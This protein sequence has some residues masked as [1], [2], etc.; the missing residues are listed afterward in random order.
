M[1]KYLFPQLK[2]KPLRKQ[3]DMYCNWK[4]LRYPLVANTQRRVIESFFQFSGID[5]TSLI[6]Q[7]M[8]ESY[9]IT[10]HSIFLQNQTRASL[11]QFCKYWYKLG[12]LTDEFGRVIK[13]D[14]ITDMENVHPLMHTD[15][16]ERVHRLRKEGLSLRQIK[17]KMEMQDGKSYH[18]RQIHRWANYK[19]SELST[20][21]S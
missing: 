10:N 13:K 7:P 1:L 14:I 5:C 16:V 20:G 18:L 21:S 3:I 19:L 4:A 9:V 15:Q 6:T 2:P 12:V 17:T 11:M 8:I